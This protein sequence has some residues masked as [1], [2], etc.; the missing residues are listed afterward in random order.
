MH[1]TDYGPLPDLVFLILR[2]SMSNVRTAPLLSAS[3]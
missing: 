3:T 1:A 2:S